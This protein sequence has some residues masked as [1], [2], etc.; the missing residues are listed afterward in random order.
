MKKLKRRYKIYAFNPHEDNHLAIKDMGEALN[1]SD[2][3]CNIGRP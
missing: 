2:L 1:Q 3:D